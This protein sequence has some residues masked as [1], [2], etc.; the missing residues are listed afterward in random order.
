MKW[1]NV[2]VSQYFE[3]FIAGATKASVS[4]PFLYSGTSVLQCS[5]GKY[6]NIMAALEIVLLQITNKPD[7][8]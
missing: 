2:T 8:N 3:Q 1:D 4:I 7:L 6:F 5:L